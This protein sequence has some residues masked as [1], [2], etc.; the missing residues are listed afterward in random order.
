MSDALP[1]WRFLAPDLQAAILEGRQPAHLKL[2]QFI[3]RPIPIDW[4]EQRAIFQLD[5]AR[6]K[7][8]HRS[9]ASTLAFAKAAAAE[10]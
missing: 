4:G 7:L 1:A 2:E 6:S 9:Q 3:E 5:C 10:R 8:R